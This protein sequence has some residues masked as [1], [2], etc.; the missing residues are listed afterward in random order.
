MFALQDSTRAMRRAIFERDIVPA[1]GKRLLNEVKPD[2]L[3]H[4]CTKVKDRGA[5]STAIHVRDILKQ[6]YV[7]A[8][9]R[10]EKAANPAD[11]VAP[12]TIATF[13]L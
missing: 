4:L 5:P 2:D 10:G 11:K 12:A 1:F 3:R 9:L 13:R 7:Y 8:I 6:I